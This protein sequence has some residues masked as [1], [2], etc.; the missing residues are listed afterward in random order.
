MPLPLVPIALGIAAGLTIDELVDT[1]GEDALDEVLFGGKEKTA[2]K[3]D[4]E[5]IQDLQRKLALGG[6]GAVAGGVIKSVKGVAKVKEGEILTSLDKMFKKATKGKL[7]DAELEKF[8]KTSGIDADFAKDVREAKRA[9]DNAVSVG[10]EV[11]FELSDI[12]GAKVSPRASDVDAGVFDELR[13]EAERT[14]RSTANKADNKFNRM[15]QKIADRAN[16]VDRVIDPMV[17]EGRTARQAVTGKIK[18]GVDKTTRA[19]HEM[20]SKPMDAVDAGIGA[21]KTGAAKLGGLFSRM[22]PADAKKAK[23][24]AKAAKK[25]NIHP[26]LIAAGLGGAGLAGYL[27]N[28]ESLSPED[29]KLLE[30]AKAG[31]LKQIINQT[32]PTPTPDPEEIRRQEARRRSEEIDRKIDEMILKNLGGM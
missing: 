24:A 10:S 22:K 31:N 26:V 5:A 7:K 27:F 25:A 2:L 1:F 14:A 12:G 6:G 16:D 4:P 17:R 20:A 32:K 19:I 29:A 28:N 18:G 15:A 30:D 11:D 3:E 8:I 13:D 23:K 21:T 9:I